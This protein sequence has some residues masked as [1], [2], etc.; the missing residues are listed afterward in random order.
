MQQVVS[1]FGGI[2]IL[3]NGAGA[4]FHSGN[5]DEFAEKNKN[6]YSNI[7]GMIILSKLV[8]PYLKRGSSIINTTSTISYLGDHESYLP[9]KGAVVSFTLSLALNVMSRGINV[10]VI[11]SNPL[12]PI[13]T[14]EV[15]CQENLNNSLVEREMYL[16]EIAK[17]FL[18]LVTE[19]ALEITGQVFNCN[20]RSI[21]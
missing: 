12:M 7:V 1:E 9:S 13:N 21:C 17:R 19:E 14:E 11:A 6:S 18:F 4:Y 2:D 15:C 8:L 3:I 16:Q 20:N 5:K 10:N